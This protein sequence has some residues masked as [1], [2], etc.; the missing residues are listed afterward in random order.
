MTLK[1]KKKNVKLCKNLDLVEKSIKKKADI[2]LVNKSKFI[3]KF[4]WQISLKD[5]I[6]EEYLNESLNKMKN[7]K[8]NINHEEDKSMFKIV[9]FIK[10]N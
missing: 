3:I 5:D 7:E 4:H 2:L 9:I 1:E 10:N 6:I 8:N